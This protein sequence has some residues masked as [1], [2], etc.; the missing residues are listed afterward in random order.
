MTV[1]NE[2]LLAGAVSITIFIVIFRFCAVLG[3]MET[4]CV[5]LIVSQ[6]GYQ[7]PALQE[8]NVVY[9]H[10]YFKL[11]GE[12]LFSYP[13]LFTLRIEVKLV[14]TCSLFSPVF[15]ALSCV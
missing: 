11:L 2:V 13:Q 15:A 4:H 9:C 12:K 14:S 6:Y 3:V 10:V 1:K 7:L 8:D 5:F